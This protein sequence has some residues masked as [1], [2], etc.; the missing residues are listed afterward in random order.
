MGEI[1]S[2]TPRPHHFD[3][4]TYWFRGISRQWQFREPVD[5]DCQIEPDVVQAASGHTFVITCR[6]GPELCLP[7]GAH[8]TLEVRTI[9]TS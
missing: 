1:M 7:T 4:T 8:V 5:L 3:N 6:L 9:S 2:Q